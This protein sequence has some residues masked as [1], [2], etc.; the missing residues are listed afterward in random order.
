[1]TDR[2]FI[3]QG[4]TGEFSD[5]KRWTVAAYADETLA[6]EHARLATADAERWEKLGFD[7]QYDRCEAH[8]AAMPDCKCGHCQDPG[9]SNDVPP[10]GWTQY[11]PRMRV[12]YNGAD[13]SVETVEL[14][15]ALPEGAHHEEA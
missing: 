3:V 15:T 5:T 4:H 12:S 10:V 9:W 6:K 2:I 1:M 13:Y 7:E 8:R 14:R 11:D